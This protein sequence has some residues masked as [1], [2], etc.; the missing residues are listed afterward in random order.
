M[1]TRKLKND[2]DTYMHSGVGISKQFQN[3]LHRQDDDVRQIY[4]SLSC[5]NKYR[6]RQDWTQDYQFH[7]DRFRWMVWTNR[8]EFYY[9]YPDDRHRE[10]KIRYPIPRCIASFEWP[11]LPSQKPK[12]GC[13]RKGCSPSR[14]SDSDASSSKKARQ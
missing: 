5:R 6:F 14:S 10:E 4:E 3:W 13:I 9:R 8:H 11:M 12:F 7:N 1:S 2:R